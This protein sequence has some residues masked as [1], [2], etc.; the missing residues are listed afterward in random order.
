MQNVVISVN[1]L[2]KSFGNFI[3]N[4]H[5]TFEVYQGEIFGFL[6]ANG[7]GKT[8]LI[9]SIAG[10]ISFDSG[11]ITFDGHTIAKEPLEF[12]KQLAYIP[13]HPDLYE[14]LSGRQFIDF[15]ADAFNVSLER[16]NQ[17]IG[18]YAA[19]FEMLDSLD[20]PIS[21]YSH[22]MKQKVTI[23]AALVHEPKLWLLDE[24]LTG[25]DP[26]SIY[27][28]KECMRQ[29]A[30]KGN[31]VMFSSHI[32]DVVDQQMLRHEFIDQC[33]PSCRRNHRNRIGPC[34]DYRPAER[35]L[36]SSGSEKHRGI[37][38]VIARVFYSGEMAVW[39]QSILRLPGLIADYSEGVLRHPSGDR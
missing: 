27:Q 34:L 17:L 22:G 38:Q 9:K 16:R 26:D 39:R 18:K 24:P 20:K 7:A 15:I 11:T 10:I 37:A 21:S 33:P 8:T 4:D 29:H 31:I 6:G 1:N 23:I 3:A 5:L 35:L 32:I 13:D 36:E 12:K 14:T 28:V 30:A 25:L 19:E 2:V